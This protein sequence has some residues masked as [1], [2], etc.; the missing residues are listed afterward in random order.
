METLSKALTY[1]A[2]SSSKSQDPSLTLEKWMEIDAKLIK[3]IYNN[4]HVSQR[5][6]YKME[7]TSHNLWK[8][9]KTYHTQRASIEISK[10]RGELE[11][12]RF[13]LNS[14]SKTFIRIDKLQ[15]QL[16]E[17]GNPI[18]DSELIQALTR[19]LE[20]FPTLHSTLCG[21]NVYG[22]MTF[23]GPNKLT[24]ELFKLAIERD[25]FIGQT[26]TAN[27]FW[28]SSDRGKF[29]R[30]KLFSKTDKIDE[31]KSSNG[32]SSRSRKCW[33]CNS[34]EHLARK[35]PQRS[36]SSSLDQK[37]KNGNA[38]LASGLASSTSNKSGDWYIDTGASM[39]VCNDL[40][41]L[42]D[43][44][45]I[46]TQELTGLNGTK[47]RANIAGKVI[48]T[49]IGTAYRTV[50]ISNVLYIP[51]AAANLLSI[52]ALRSQGQGGIDLLIRGD[53]CSLIDKEGDIIL[54][55]N[56]ANGILAL[57]AVVKRSLAMLA[58]DIWH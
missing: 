36:N 49:P 16:I 55:G 5:F 12:L 24:F 22:E 57:N 10:V 1:M 33:T 58:M 32:S 44:H 40:N 28:A 14:I 4:L 25:A 3:I 23:K 46:D 51:G 17:Y 19:K 7:H 50:T 38:L 8:A 48:F 11:N 9:I 37:S 15:E 54:T 43:A 13:N 26:A 35:C 21:L 31:A 42:T 39:H 45:K 41:S 47:M 30:D 6:L 52:H 29:K 2:I 20:I 56:C 53:E 34:T 27:G 18:Q